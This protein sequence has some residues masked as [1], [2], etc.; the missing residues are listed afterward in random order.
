MPRF[1]TLQTRFTQGEIDPLMIGRVDVDQYYGAGEFLRNVFTM[2]QGGVRRRPGLEFIGR[3]LGQ[4]TLATPNAATAPNGGTAANGYD[5]NPANTV[6]TTTNISTTNNYVVLRYDM[7][8]AVAM[9]TV[10][11]YDLKLSAAGSSS[12]FFIQVSTDD[13]TWVTKGEALAISDTGKNFSRRIHGSYRYIRLV[14]VGTTDL[15]TRKVELDDMLV[16]TEGAVSNSKLINFE[17]NVTQTYVFVFTDKN[18]A[19]YQNGVYLIDLR[20]ADYTHARIPYIDWLQ[21]ADTLLV[22][23]ED[24][25]TKSIVRGSDNDIW[26]VASVTYTN[27]PKYYFGEITGASDDEA[28]IVDLSALNTSS[29]FYFIIDG[30]TSESVQL[31]GTGATNASNIETAINAMANIGANGVSVTN[32]GNYVMNITFDGTNTAGRP[33]PLITAIVSGGGGSISVRRTLGGG[34]EIWSAT[35]GWPRHAGLY[36]GRIWIDGGKSRPTVV[37]GSKVNSLFDYNFGTAQDDEAIGP[38][39]FE[40]YNNIE[41]IYPG[42]SLM[43]FTSGGEYILPQPFGD[44]L[45]PGNVT[46]ARQSRVGSAGYLRPQETEGGVLYVQRGGKSVQEFIY[47]DSQQAY[48]NN[49]VSLLSSHLVDS[50]VDFALRRATNTEDGAYLLMVLEDGSLTVVN[51]LRNQG[52]AAFTKQ[53]TEGE[54]KNCTAD[55]EDMYFV[56]AREINGSDVQYLERF[57]GDHYT[58]AS[59]R[60]TTGLP[61]SDFNVPQLIAEECRVLADGAIMDNATPDADGDF[62]I[63]RDAEESLEIGINFTPL[64]KDLPVENPQLGSV[65]GMPVNISQV[66]LRLSE[67]AGIKVNGKTVSFRGFAPSGS[68]SPLDA[69]PTR[70]TGVKELKGWRGWTDGGQVEITQDDPLPLTLLALS[71]RVNV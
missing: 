64:I 71:K 55:V 8:A 5:D 69:V 52:I 46:V 60:F 37:Y 44:P 35:R 13:A 14:R 33:W 7:G 47:D 2:P 43:V 12:E 19:V 22:Y 28:Q 16:Y 38:L 30:V 49:L 68:G 29:Y 4:L 42:R 3:V 66:I 58:D 11:L 51:V 65:I 56:V 40:G 21:N 25:Q 17:F 61:E 39:G 18:I 15:G 54:F 63:S 1:K 70:F 34:E 36:Q 57:N 41:A 50:P 62:S 24:V 6:L 26:T 9:G 59:T 53:T 31:T 27:I 45:T 67:T 23:H 10:Y 48:A 32:T 20:T